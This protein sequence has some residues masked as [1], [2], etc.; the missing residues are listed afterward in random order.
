[1]TAGG[2][3]ASTR[4]FSLV[5]EVTPMST[6]EKVILKRMVAWFPVYY[7]HPICRLDIGLAA[8]S[9][10]WSHYTN[11]FPG[12][13]WPCAADRKHFSVFGWRCVYQARDSLFL[14]TLGGLCLSDIY[15]W[16]GFLH[17]LRHGRAGDSRWEG[18]QNRSGPF[19]RL[20]PQQTSPDPASHPLGLICSTDLVRP[21]PGG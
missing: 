9:F 6:R 8:G 14:P 7:T 18:R 16:Q 19:C 12:N 21:K 17:L 5:V 10:V 20:L 1:M 13:R 11:T 3:R 15:S 4:P 2:V